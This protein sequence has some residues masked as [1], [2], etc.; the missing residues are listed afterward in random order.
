[1]PLPPT[2]DKSYKTSEKEKS[3][4]KGP[5][6]HRS[7]QYCNYCHGQGTPTSKNL[8][9]EG[10]DIP[11]CRSCHPISVYNIHVV[12]I[13]PQK[14]TVPPEFPLPDGKIT[15]V[16]CH[17]E[18]S[19][20]SPEH[21]S[22]KRPF[23]LRG[24]QSGF[25]FCFSCHSEK[26]YEAYNPHDP[27]HLSKSAERTN[28]CLFCH[29]AELPVESRR[30]LAF[31]SLKGTPND[32]CTACHIEEPHFGIPAHLQAQ[33]Q[34]AYAWMAEAAKQAGPRLPMGEGNVCLCVSCHDPHMPGL[35]RQPEDDQDVWME[36]GTS[37][38][39]QEY[40]T[41]DLYPFVKNQVARLEITYGRTLIIKEPGLFHKV[42]RKLFRHGLQRD[43]SLC[44]W[45]HNVFQEDQE[46]E[47]DR[48]LRY[49]ILY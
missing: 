11:L 37:D 35:L 38:L 9:Y 46:Y 16:T 3:Y 13:K 7:S 27:K 22:W 21:I 28:N 19:C 39:R 18:P 23:F 24:T 33:G 44:L 20:R 45:C 34:K 2:W 48:D 10:Q 32:L 26:T 8:L 12:G 49:R 6:V 42:R 14:V 43:G 31:A 15:C 4:I 30:G 17:Q 29:Q 40:L 36:A 47:K 5:N 1:M 25:M 41:K